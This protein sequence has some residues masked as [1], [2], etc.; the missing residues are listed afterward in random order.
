M[1]NLNNNYYAKVRQQQVYT[2][3][4][5]AAVEACV[6]SDLFTFILRS[7]K[8]LKNELA[9]VAKESGLNQVDYLNSV[10]KFYNRKEERSF[11]SRL[12]F[13]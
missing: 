1:E 3:A 9:Q 5:D 11:F 8:A 6:K 10:T 12:I 13:G 7:R 4:L 2:N